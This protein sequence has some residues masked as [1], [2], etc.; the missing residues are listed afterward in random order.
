[1]FYVYMLWTFYV[2]F[3]YPYHGYVTQHPKDY[4][5]ARIDKTQQNSRCRLCGDRFYT[6]SHISECSKLAQKEYKTRH[7]D[8]PVGIVQEVKFDLKN[9]WFMLNPEF[10]LDNETHKRLWDFEI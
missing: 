5:K 6:I 9:K 3:T 10:V 8:N 4:V 1:M 2:R 7:E